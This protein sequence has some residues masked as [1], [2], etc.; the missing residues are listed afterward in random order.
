MWNF[1]ATKKTKTGQD[2]IWKSNL[3]KIIITEIVSSSYCCRCTF[4]CLP[5]PD[6]PDHHLEQSRFGKQ[7][8]GKLGPVW[9]F[10]WQ[11]SW[12][13]SNWRLVWLISVVSTLEKIARSSGKLCQENGAETPRRIISSLMILKQPKQFQH[14]LN[15][16]TYYTMTTGIINN[17]QWLICNRVYWHFWFSG[18]CYD[19]AIDILKLDSLRSFFETQT[20]DNLKAIDF[21]AFRTFH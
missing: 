10:P 2:K 7:S 19:F 18:L 4:F 9:Y 11:S 3:S 8:S 5:Q 6:S 14:S 12:H 1:I 13:H 21:Q 15:I 17:Q 20:K 16:L